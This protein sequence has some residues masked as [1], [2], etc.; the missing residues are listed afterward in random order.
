MHIVCMV[1]AI[2]ALLASQLATPADVRNNPGFGRSIA[3]LVNLLIGLGFLA[4]VSYYVLINGHSM[5][6]HYNGVIGVKF[7]FLLG[8]GALVGISKKNSKGDLFRW[9]GFGL[10]LLASLFGAT[11]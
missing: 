3:R 1:G 10:L 6:P 8:A 7:V 4:G 11:L 5:G 2:G 9:C